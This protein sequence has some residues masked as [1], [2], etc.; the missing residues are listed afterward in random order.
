MAT[1]KDDLDIIKAAEKDTNPLTL[2]AITELDNIG[3]LNKYGGNGGGGGDLWP[4]VPFVIRVTGHEISYDDAPEWV[5]NEALPGAT[6]QVLDLLKNDL[7]TY[8]MTAGY[9]VIVSY[10]DDLSFALKSH[11]G[12]T[13]AVNILENDDHDPILVKWNMSSS[14]IVISILANEA[15]AI[16]NTK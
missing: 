8:P 6:I 2:N 1:Y 10:P 9:V 3:K 11:M 15:Y 16:G 13:Y 12:D 7:Q 14:L 4:G 5:K